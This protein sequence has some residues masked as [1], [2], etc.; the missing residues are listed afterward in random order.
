MLILLEPWLNAFAKGVGGGYIANKKNPP[1]QPRTKRKK[2]PKCNAM[3]TFIIHFMSKGGAEK[4]KAQKATGPLGIHR[5]A[6]LLATA[7]AYSRNQ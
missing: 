7:I 3:R 2:T 6:H 1:N 4:V 5:P